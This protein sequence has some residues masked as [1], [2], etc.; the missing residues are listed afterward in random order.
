MGG[1]QKPKVSGRHFR[2]PKD[3]SVVSGR[4]DKK[5]CNLRLRT[6]LVSVRIQDSPIARVGNSLPVILITLSSGPT[7]VVI[8]PRTREAIGS[9]FPPEIDTLIM[10]LEN[11]VSYVAKIL[12]SEGADILV[13]VSP[14]GL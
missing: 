10:C 6:H 13:E 7:A 4:F 9:L 1:S 3:D 14:V 11:G 2:S 5:N 8:D 12:E